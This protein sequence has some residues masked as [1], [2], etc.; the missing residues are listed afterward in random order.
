LPAQQNA[1][2][3]AVS[4]S[5]IQLPEEF[6]KAM[7]LDRM[8]IPALTLGAGQTF[9]AGY[10]G[11]VAYE[12]T[13]RAD[14]DTT[15]DGDAATARLREWSGIQPGSDLDAQRRK[16]YAR[17]F[18]YVAG[19]GTH[20]GDYKLPHHD[21]QNG[22]L[23]VVYKGVVAALA[24]VNGARGGVKFDSTADKPKVYKHLAQHYR[25]FGEEPPESKGEGL[26]LVKDTVPVVNVTRF[27]P[28]DEIEK[29]LLKHIHNLDLPALA[30]Q[31]AQQALAKARGR[32]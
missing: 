20:L 16:Q 2:V 25:Q 6:I 31:I 7:D 19:D 14:K 28:L 8:S 1:I 32:V 29:A 13:P 3:E 24:A 26:V 5:A 4:K 30:N 21:I 15:W 10:K 18:A 12:E 11:P 9:G 17:G 22:K 23:L 27:V